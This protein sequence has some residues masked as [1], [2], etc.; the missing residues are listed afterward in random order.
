M[1]RPEDETAETIQRLQT[2]LA[3]EKLKNE[4]AN[5]ELATM[6]K[7]SVDQVMLHHHTSS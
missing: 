5:T 2:E 7:R 4:S 3:A 1:E 6:R